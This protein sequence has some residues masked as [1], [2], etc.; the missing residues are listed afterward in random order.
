MCVCVCM[1]VWPSGWWQWDG[2]GAKFL[3]DLGRGDK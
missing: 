3:W 2:L 1:C